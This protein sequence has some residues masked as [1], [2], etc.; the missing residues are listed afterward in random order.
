MA[1]RTWRER[2]RPIVAEVLQATKG[3][4]ERAIKASLRDA[5]NSISL[6]VRGV[7]P[8]RAWLEE[9]RWQRGLSTR[10]KKT[11]PDVDERQ[12]DLFGSE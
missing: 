5:W 10:K 11:D 3:Q 9:A 6:G 8:Y 12:L 7:Y 1:Y 2:A 4:S